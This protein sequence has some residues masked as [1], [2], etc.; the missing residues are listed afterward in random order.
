MTSPAQ[1]LFH[2]VPTLT[3]E[4]REY[5]LSRYWR[6]LFPAR[7]PESRIKRKWPIGKEGPRLQ[8]WRAAI[9]RTE[10]AHHL[11]ATIATL[12][13]ALADT[14]TQL[15]HLTHTLECVV[16]DDASEPPFPLPWGRVRVGVYRCL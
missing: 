3:S 1:G 15:R 11:A 8:A 14:H 4:I 7:S 16:S 6:A 5:R 12:S 10:Q 13:T 2:A 9:A